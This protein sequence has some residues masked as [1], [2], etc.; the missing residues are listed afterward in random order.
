MT[1]R[2]PSKLVPI[3]PIGFALAKPSVGRYGIEFQ[4][5]QARLPRTAQRRCGG[6]LKTSCPD[7]ANGDTMR[8]DNLG[9]IREASMKFSAFCL[10]TA[11]LAVFA[12]P[13]SAHHS[14]AMFDA[15][16]NVTLQGTVKE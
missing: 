1:A 2:L 4:R 10:A 11:A 5:V 14:F 6:W 15:S 16:K 13:A 7:L 12:V 3:V 9:S 8:C